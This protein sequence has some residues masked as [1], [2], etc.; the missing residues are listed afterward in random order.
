MKINVD[1]EYGKL[2]NVLMCSASGYIENEKEDP[3]HCNNP[4]SIHYSGV[5]KPKL[6]DLIR[7]QNEFH[8]TIK[9]HSSEIIL[10]D[11]VESAS[12][13]VFTR[14]LSFVIGDK[15][16]ISNLKEP[17]RQVERSGLDGII[18]SMDS[19]VIYFPEGLVIEG[20]D[21]INHGKD[22][23]VGFGDRTA[24]ESIDYLQKTLGN[25]YKV[26]AIPLGIN[27]QTGKKILHLDCVF[28]ILSDKDVLLYKGGL[29][30]EVVQ[31]IMK[32][33]DPIEINADEQF[34]LGSNIFCLGNNTVVTQKI[35]QARR[36]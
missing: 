21:V 3:A 2:K 23:F 32:K 13:Q 17:S 14:D 4:T 34:S 27:M 15:F 9:K 5:L 18:K 10:A 33:F 24:K 20:G 1:N 12:V 7:E 25:K 16:F 26:H 19:E 29:S 36:F 28:T 11:L 31:I 35:G 6:K 22:I 30:S 8:N